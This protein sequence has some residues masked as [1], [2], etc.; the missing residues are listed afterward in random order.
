MPGNL[1]VKCK[2]RRYCGKEVCSILSKFRMNVRELNQN[3]KQ[4][5]D[6]SSPPSVFIGSKLDYPNVNVGVMSLPSIK[7]NAWIYDSPNF[8]SKENLLAERIT[9]FRKSMINSRFRSKV[10]DIQKNSSLLS[11]IQEIGMTNMQ[12]DVEVSLKKKPIPRMEFDE[13]VLPMGSSGQ[14][15]NLKVISNPKIPQHV[16]KVYYDT[17]LKSR[18]ALNYLYK[19]G[20]EEHYLSKILSV[21]VTGL[22]KNRKLVSTRNSISAVDDNIGR[23]LLEKIRDYRIIDC[24]FLHFGG[25]L[26]NYYMLLF[27]PEIFSYELFESVFPRTTWNLSSSVEIM[28]DY[29]SYSGRKNY[30]EETA[31]GYYAARLPILQYLESEKR[32]ASV[33]VLRFVLPDYD[34][35]LGVWVCRNSVRKSLESESIKFES[36]ENMIDY[37]C[38]FIKDKMKFDINFILE[39]SRILNEIKKQRKL[40]NYF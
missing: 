3:L 8:W 18:E 14:L 27:F 24:C 22:K 5:F 30:A 13:H 40:N 35:P 39:R 15:K 36:R 17:D 38:N 37:A 10:F 16:E 1:C 20:L 9:D 7:Q 33:L 6:G 29:E 2:G 11:L 19:K 25:H 28:T 23:F 21:G 34:T 32:Q 31:G 4:E 26:G 12:A